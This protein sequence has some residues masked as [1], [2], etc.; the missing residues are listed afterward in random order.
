MSFKSHQYRH[1]VPDIINFFLTCPHQLAPG[2]IFMIVSLL[3]NEPEG[4]Q[5]DYDNEN[6][7]DD[8]ENA[9]SVFPLSSIGVNY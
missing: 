2:R 6:D 9:G 7:D 3:E 1:V 5:E 8:S 4:L